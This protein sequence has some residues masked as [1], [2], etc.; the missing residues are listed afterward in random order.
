MTLRIV[1]IVIAVAG[2]GLGSRLS[3]QTPGTDEA[4]QTAEGVVT[5]LY[6]LVTF[7]AGNPPDWDRVRSLFLDD[8]VIVLRTT[9]TA[10][11]VFDVDGFVND[12]VTFIERPMVKERGFAEKIL[13]TKP[14]IFGDMAHMWVL[15]EA[16]IPGSPRAPQQ[17]VDSFSLIRRQG[18]W[19]IAA[20]TNEIPGPDRPLP[21]ELRG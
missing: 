17:G 20:V 7:E 15:Y 10:T 1:G 12:F 21:A 18:R 16:S 14:T 9:R 13:R 5:R 4:L 11:T 8:A 3:A 6:E 2:L 19:W